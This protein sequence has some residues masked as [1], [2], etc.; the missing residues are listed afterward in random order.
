MTDMTPIEAHTWQRWFR[1]SFSKQPQHK[2]ELQ[3]ENHMASLG[4]KAALITVGKLD[5]LTTK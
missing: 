3:R 5:A 2:P 1:K 4:L